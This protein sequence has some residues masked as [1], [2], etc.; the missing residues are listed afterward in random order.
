[1]IPIW[2][3]KLD[4]KADEFYSVLIQKLYFDQK[5]GRGEINIP[6]YRLSLCFMD[7]AFKCN[8]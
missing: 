3:D 7:P 8:I 2:K 5:S 6:Q 4:I 1:V